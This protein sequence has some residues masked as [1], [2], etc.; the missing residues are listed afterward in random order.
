MIASKANVQVYTRSAIIL[1]PTSNCNLG[2]GNEFIMRSIVHY[3]LSYLAYLGPKIWK[4]LTNNLKKFES[5]VAFKFK[6]KS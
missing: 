3:G 6:I 1:Q 5:V 2:N 4:L